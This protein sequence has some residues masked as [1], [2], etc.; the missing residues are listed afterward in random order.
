MHGQQNIKIN[1]LFMWG[2]DEWDVE[3][4]SWIMNVGF[5]SYQTVSTERILKN[6]KAL[7]P[8]EEIW[9]YFPPLFTTT[10]QDY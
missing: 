2:S 1:Y 10:Q 6:L 7:T 3:E 4:V 9:L 8:I 5:S